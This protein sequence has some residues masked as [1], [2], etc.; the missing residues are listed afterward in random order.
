[1][2]V[3]KDSA[4]PAHARTRVIASDLYMSHLNEYPEFVSPEEKRV[5]SYSNSIW[6]GYSILSD[7]CPVR[8]CFIR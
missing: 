5:V 2:Y 3:C 6:L 4:A 8:K 1:M 7:I